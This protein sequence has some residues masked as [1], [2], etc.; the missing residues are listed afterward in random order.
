MKMGKIILMPV[1]VLNIFFFL[2][3][4]YWNDRELKR[5]PC[6]NDEFILDPHAQSCSDNA[7]VP[8]LQR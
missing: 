4:S 3:G 7:C 1:T 6:F 2:F 5:L 8:C